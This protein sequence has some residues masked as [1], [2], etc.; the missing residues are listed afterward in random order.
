MRV[1]G[2]MCFA[3]PT[4]SLALSLCRISILNAEHTQIKL[5]ASDW[6]SRRGQSKTDDDLTRGWLQS[7]AARHRLNEHAQV[8]HIIHTFTPAHVLRVYSNFR[9]LFASLE[10]ETCYV[11]TYNL[12]RAMLLLT[13]ISGCLLSASPIHMCQMNPQISMLYQ[14][15]MHSMKRLTVNGLKN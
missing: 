9:L 2:R 7:V 8:V 13:I 10:L 3:R 5:H 12:K 15:R 11:V 1:I 6:S 14:M 4:F